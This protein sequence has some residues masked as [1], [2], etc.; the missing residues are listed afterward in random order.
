MTLRIVTCLTFDDVPN[1]RKN[2]AIAPSYGRTD[3]WL[4]FAAH[5]TRPIFIWDFTSGHAGRRNDDASGVTFAAGGR[6]LTGR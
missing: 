1:K 5:M 6:P 3:E 2:R 4:F